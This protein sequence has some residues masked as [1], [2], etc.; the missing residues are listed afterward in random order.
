MIVCWS[1][2][3]LAVDL[4]KKFGE[5]NLESETVDKCFTSHI[6]ELKTPIVNFCLQIASSFQDVM[7]F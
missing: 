4:T 1:E 5:L 3:H 7:L 6:F 2:Q